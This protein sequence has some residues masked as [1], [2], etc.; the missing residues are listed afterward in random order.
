MTLSRTYC[1]IDQKR[2]CAVTVEK[3]LSQLAEARCCQEQCSNFFE[4]AVHVSR[5]KISPVRSIFH[6]YLV[7]R[8][9]KHAGSPEAKSVA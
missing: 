9:V 2:R 5:I 7:R 1:G 3:Y 4:K 8:L 6:F